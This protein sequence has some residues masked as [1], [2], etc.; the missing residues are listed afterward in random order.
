MLLADVGEVFGH[1]VIPFA[2]EDETRDALSKTLATRKWLPMLRPPRLSSMAGECDLLL[3]LFLQDFRV[4]AELQTEVIEPH[5]L[6]SSWIYAI[7]YEPVDDEAPESDLEFFIYLRVHRHFYGSYGIAGERTLHRAICE[8][9]RKHRAAQQLSGRILYS[10]GWPD[11]ILHGRTYGDLRQLR[12][13]IVGLQSLSFPTQPPTGGRRE[14]RAPIFLKTITLLGLP[15]PFSG[16]SPKSVAP[17]GTALRSPMLLGRSRPGRAIDAILAAKDIFARG[18]AKSVT[19]WALDGSWDFVITTADEIPLHRFYES[20]R[21]VRGNFA[22]RGIDRTQTHILTSPDEELESLR[23]K[24][25]TLKPTPRGRTLP[26]RCACGQQHFHLERRLLE[27]AA[28]AGQ[29]PRGLQRT[30]SHALEMFRHTLRDSSNCCDSLGALLAHAQGLGLLLRRLHFF[31]R[32]H[33]SRGM[34]PQQQAQFATEISFHN[35][36]LIE[37]CKRAGRVVR[38]KNAG[39]ASR[40]FLQVDSIVAQRGAIPKILMIAERIMQ[41]F[42]R[43]LPAALPGRGKKSLHTRFAAILEPLGNVSSQPLM[44]LVAIPVRY[45]FA[46]HW[47]VPQLWHEV[48]Q[49]VF[50]AEYSPSQRARV[51]REISLGVGDPKLTPSHV[52]FESFAIDYHLRAD[53]FADLLVFCFGFRGVWDDFFLYLSSLTANVAKHDHL[54][55]HSWERQVLALT[56]RLYFVYQFAFVHERLQKI[57]ARLGRRLSRSEFV[58]ECRRA[59]EA[60]TPDFAHSEMLARSV[61]RHLKRVSTPRRSWPAGYEV[62]RNLAEIVAGNLSASKVYERCLHDLEVLAYAFRDEKLG[63]RGRGIGRANWA[64]IQRG[65]LIDFDSQEQLQSAYHEFYLD[66]LGA[67]TKRKGGEGPRKAQFRKMATLG[68]SALLHIYQTETTR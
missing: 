5:S 18:G 58:S 49:H 39:S 34:T 7:P 57:A 51:E 46:L 42:Y 27:H 43:Q 30:I 59:L 41:A 29:L 63:A 1:F 13:L 12:Q 26:E 9:L 17:A 40:L 50:W 61:I 60:L 31:H 48:G 62:P 23:K 14:Y 16:P 47:V 38:E 6:A 8:L 21:E 19:S 36:H 52:T 37:W 35:E 64:R 67:Q 24:P 25:V 55:P 3:H 53:M 11:L 45:A 4:V 32:L 56:H 20:M 15:S 28:E 33:D 44:G 10:L 66:E 2:A 54:H 68:R 65:E 22:E